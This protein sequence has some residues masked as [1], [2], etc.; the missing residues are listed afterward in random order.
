[1]NHLHYEKNKEHYLQ[2]AKQWAQNHSEV[3][4]PHSNAYHR[5]Y[6]KRH[7]ESIAE[8]K[9]EAK[10]RLVDSYIKDRLSQSGIKSPSAELIQLKREQIIMKR[11]IKKIKEMLNESDNRHVSEKQS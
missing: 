6:R 1:M 11:N 8:Y 4:Y 9:R 3:K 7:S 10:F 5:A 2:L